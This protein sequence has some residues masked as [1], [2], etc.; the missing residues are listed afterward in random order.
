MK[1]SAMNWNTAARKL[2]SWLRPS[3]G[4]TSSDQSDAALTSVES[5]EVD[6]AVGP[7]VRKLRRRLL[8]RKGAQLLV[9]MIDRQ[10]KGMLSV[11][12]VYGVVVYWHDGSQASD[13]GATNVLD[14]HVAQFYAPKRQS[15]SLA[16]DHLCKAF[17]QG[18][19][20]EFGW[21]RR[22]DG[23]VFWGVTVVEPL[24]LADG[25]LQGFTH[26]TRAVNEPRQ[27][28]AREQDRSTSVWT[29][30]PSLRC[31]SVDRTPHIPAFA[32][33]FR[34]SFPT[35]HLASRLAA[36]AAFA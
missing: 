14:Q 24:V 1:A 28:V 25:R 7:K 9:S 12:D 5:A 3:D 10:D 30:V 31:V 11:L 6:Q 8:S 15:R 18:S 4:S 21:R 19:R 35:R 32:R 33:S 2:G 36:R 20:S 34:L 29:D 26:V 27:H 17:A 23:T 16:N 22:A 13:A